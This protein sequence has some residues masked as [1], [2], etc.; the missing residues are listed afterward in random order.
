ML[1]NNGHYLGR[2][3]DVCYTSWVQARDR[4]NCLLTSGAISS[5]E[6]AWDKSNFNFTLLLTLLENVTF[7][8]YVLL[9]MVL[10][11]RSV[12]G[13]KVERLIRDAPLIGAKITYP[14]SS[15]VSSSLV[16]LAAPPSLVLSP[17]WHRA[18]APPVQLVQM[19]LPP[20]VHLDL[21]YH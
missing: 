19:S 5:S 10:F 11:F 2:V 20:A 15:W 7:P 14:F 1:W 12:L 3:G 13:K 16:A 21:H 17:Q 9:I 18:L 6:V 8:V 4:K